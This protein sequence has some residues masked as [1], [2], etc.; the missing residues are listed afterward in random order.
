MADRAFAPFL[1]DLK[2]LPNLVSLTRIALICVA[3]G[4]TYA[5]YPGP[6]LAL[7][8]PAGLSDYL[9]GYLARKRNESTELGAL[10]DAL[11]DILFNLVCLVLAAKYGV[12][13]FYLL[14]L[15]GFRDMTVMALRAS[16]GQQGFTIPSSL[17]A[18][19]AVNFNYYSYVLLGLVIMEPFGPDHV[20]TTGI[21]WLGLFG[22]HAGITMQWISGFIYL[23]SYARQYR[24]L[25]P[26]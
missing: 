21:R 11:A 24:G 6:G 14:L 3:A 15:W 2:R 10:L 19:V 16:A 1:R 5:G 12:W 4:L 20:M 9:D 23:R 18:K 13:G 26:N 25:D 8:I 7:G 17:L 22:I